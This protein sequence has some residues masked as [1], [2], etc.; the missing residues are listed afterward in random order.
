MLPDTCP[1]PWRD[2]RLGLT[3]IDRRIAR[4]RVIGAIGRDLRN[5]LIDLRQQLGQQLPIT[6]IVRRDR[7]RYDVTASRIHTQMQLAPRAPLG[8][9]MTAHLPLAFPIDLDASR[10]DHHVQR[11]VFSTPRQIHCELASPP[12]QGR[13]VGHRQLHLKQC[14]HR[15]QQTLRGAQRQPIHRRQHRHAHDRYIIVRAR[16]ASS[17][18]A[19]LV[20]PGTHRRLAHPQRQ[21]SAL[22]QRGVILAPVAEAV[23]ASSSLVF[24]TSTLPAPRLRDHLCNN[25]YFESKSA[26]SILLRSANGKC[27]LPCNPTSGR[28]RKAASPPA[29]FTAST[30]FRASI[31]DTRRR[32]KARMSV[33][34]AGMRSP[35]T[36]WMGI[37]VSF[38]KSAAGTLTGSSTMSPLESGAAGG[39][40]PCGNANVTGSYETIAFTFEL[41]AAVSQ[42]NRPDCECV[43]RMAGPIRSTS[44]ASAS[45]MTSG[46]SST[47]GV[48]CLLYCVR[49]L[50]GNCVLEKKSPYSSPRRKLTNT[51]SFP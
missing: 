36:I 2:C 8:P 25:A 19:R 33:G 3:L 47:S 27:V 16:G 39:T 22:H 30:N 15:D 44:A 46:S 28:F 24:H 23:R 45:E 50:L 41:F 17:S 34:A 20:M 18:A 32:S 4:P 7:R 38:R 49:P 14:H 9:P 48:I 6:E 10:I 43:T 29:L 37:V 51:A 31:T 12:T 42:P 21:A 35:K 13:V 11:F 5:I 26:T 1:A 40:A